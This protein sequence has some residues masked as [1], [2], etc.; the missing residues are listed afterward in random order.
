MKTKEEI[1]IL[2]EPSWQ[3]NNQ[4]LKNGVNP[5]PYQLG[6]LNGYRHLENEMIKSDQQTKELKDEI[7]RLKRENQWI[8]VKDIDR[9]PDENEDLILYGKMYGWIQSGIFHNG[10]FYRDHNKLE[11]INPTHFRL[12]P[13]PPIK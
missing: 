5:F 7:E 10:T 12:S 6:F 2:S 1:I 4:Q 8:S 11:K 13:K 9:L 3:R